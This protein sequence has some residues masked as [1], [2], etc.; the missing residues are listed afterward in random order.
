MHQKL[1]GRVITFDFTIYTEWSIALGTEELQFDA[2]MHVAIAC[3]FGFLRYLRSLMFV[4]QPVVMMCIV[5]TY[6][7]VRLL[8]FAVLLGHIILAQ[9]AYDLLL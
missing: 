4:S 1:S 7:K 2:G 6:T 8:S 5:A 9:L 3:D